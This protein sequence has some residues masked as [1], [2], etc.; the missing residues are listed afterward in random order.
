METVYRSQSDGATRHIFILW[1]LDCLLNVFV[2]IE[3]TKSM[4]DG[5]AAQQRS[6]AGVNMSRDM[7]SAEETDGE[8]ALRG[9]CLCFPK[10]KVM[11]ISADFMHL[12]KKSSCYSPFCNNNPVFKKNHNNCKNKAKSCSLNSLCSHQLYIFYQ[13]C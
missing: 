6:P 9:H 5:N 7:N 2:V 8:S 1:H 13:I 4:R 12:Q 10:R 11:N 3:Y